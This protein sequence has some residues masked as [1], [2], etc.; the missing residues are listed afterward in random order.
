MLIWEDSSSTTANFFFQ[1][2]I[3]KLWGPNLTVFQ[4]LLA[5]NQ[6]FSLRN[7]GSSWLLKSVPFPFFN[8]TRLSQ[9]GESHGLFACTIGVTLRCCFLFVCFFYAETAGCFISKY[10]S[11][12][13]P[14]LSSSFPVGWGQLPPCLS[15]SPSQL[16]KAYPDCA[17]QAQIPRLNHTSPVEI[18]LKHFI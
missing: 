3:W 1:F 15:N 2:P 11:K 16:R 4:L 18:K 14:H 12:Q 8:A 6:D 10:I 13:I 5:E 17:L 7:P 9:A